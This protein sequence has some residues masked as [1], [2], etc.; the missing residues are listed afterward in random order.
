[1]DEAGRGAQSPW[2]FLLIGEPQLTPYRA[3]MKTA[4]VANIERNR[5]AMKT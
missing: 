5:P 1:M 2:P 3:T 4:R